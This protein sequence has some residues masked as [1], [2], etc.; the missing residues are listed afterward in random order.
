[1]TRRVARWSARAIAATR[2]IDAA[3]RRF[4]RLRSRAVVRLASDA[5]LQEF[6]ALAYQRDEVYDPGKPAF[7]DRLFPWEAVAIREHFPGA[8][9]R[10]LL[11][12]AGGGREALALAAQGYE[13]VAFEPAPRLAAAMAAEA[14]TVPAVHPYRAGYEDLPRLAPARGQGPAHD[15]RRL[16]PFSCAVMGWGSFAHLPTPEARLASLRAFSE[17]TDG[18]I[19]VSFLTMRDGPGRSRH[20]GRRGDEFSVFIGYYHPVDEEEMT[21]IVDTAGLRVVAMCTDATDSL[22]PHMIVQRAR[23]DAPGQR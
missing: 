6:N 10:V 11:G 22:W 23:P 21:E 20:T 9:G 4:D 14:A 7:R 19:L 15:V 12:G 5:V 13:V 1:M 17:V 3:Y 8:P 16:G 2:G 18:P